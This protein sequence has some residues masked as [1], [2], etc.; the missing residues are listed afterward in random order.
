M[1]KNSISLLLQTAKTNASD[2]II[3]EYFMLNIYLV[4]DDGC[5]VFLRFAFAGKPASGVTASHFVSRLNY[6]DF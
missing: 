5:R 2:I 1:A 4:A 3:A 6:W